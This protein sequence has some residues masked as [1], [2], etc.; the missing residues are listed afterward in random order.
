MGTKSLYCGL[1]LIQDNPNPQQRDFVPMVW[2]YHVG[3]HFEA[4]KKVF[5]LKVA[6]FFEFTEFTEV[7]I[8][9]PRRGYVF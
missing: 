7:G 8:Q 4:L 2:T 6:L 5:I 9:H 1:R 3:T